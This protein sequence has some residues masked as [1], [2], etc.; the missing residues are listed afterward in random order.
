MP[1]AGAACCACCT[2]YGPGPG[3]GFR[4][5]GPGRGWRATRLPGSVRVTAFCGGSRRVS[6][7]PVAAF[8][9]LHLLQLV[10]AACC[11]GLVAPVAA[12]PSR[13]FAVISERSAPDQRLPPAL[14]V[15]LRVSVLTVGPSERPSRP[16]SVLRR[17]ADAGRAS[18]LI[19]SSIGL[20]PR[21]RHRKHG[22]PAA[23]SLHGGPSHRCQPDPS[24]WR[25]VCVRNF[26]LPA[27]ARRAS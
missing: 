8:K 15:I 16:C 27:P 3:R 13:T 9:L 10:V 25:R 7:E 17:L 22:G 20:M 12:V 24:Q 5:S 4:V 26:R 21:F 2:C 19:I 23:A 14:R 18:V 11:C 1:G 6:A